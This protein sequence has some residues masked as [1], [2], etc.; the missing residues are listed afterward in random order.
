VDVVVLQDAGELRA[1]L[2]AAG[3]REANASSKIVEAGSGRALMAVWYDAERPHASAERVATGVAQ[4]LDADADAAVEL[5]LA[6][7]AD[8]AARAAIALCVSKECFRMPLPMPATSAAAAASA[9]ARVTFHGAGSRA[10][11][12]GAARV[13]AA[14]AAAA[15]LENLPGNVLYPS[16]LARRLAA[17]FPARA[18]TLF[19]GV[20]E[21][22]RRGFG[23][24]A[25]VGAGGERPPCVAVVDLSSARRG[26]GRASGRPEAR[27]RVLLVGKGVTYDSGGLALKPL[28][29]M[30]GMHGDMSGAAVAAAVARCV[31]AELD[32][33]VVLVLPMA[34]NLV[35]ARA[36]RPGDVLTAHGG[37]TVEVTNPDAEGRL[38]LADA[39]AYGCRRFRPDAVVDFATLTHTAETLHPALEAAF[40]AEDERVAAA[41]V[42]A[43]EASGER[44]WRM[45]PWGAQDAHLVASNVAD[46]RNAVAGPAGLAG[47]YLAAVFLR[48]FVPPELCARWVHVDLSMARSRTAG[49]LTGG[50]VALGVRV[51]AALLAADHHTQN[52][53]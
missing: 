45:P 5:Y 46:C 49:L 47:G 6:G 33:D 26:G 12:E 51:V 18:T 22:R 21:L 7:V 28:H 3:A 41:V 30:L 9:P 4:L 27:K 38:L 48:R 37:T 13:A 42:A 39:L 44:A 19:A 50:G 34:E 15:E 16:E 25:G 35:S 36:V 17:W 53:A 8:A 20:A 11:G 2:A 29:A 32:V 43:G 23:L 10:V 40:Y 14:S 31:A 24:V 1:L 52:E